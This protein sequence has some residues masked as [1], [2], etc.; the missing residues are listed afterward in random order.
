MPHAEMAGEPPAELTREQTVWAFGAASLFLTAM[1]FLGFAL[2]QGMALSFAIGWVIL[3]VFGYV[4]AL[5]FACGDLAHPLFKSQVMLHLMALV[6][7]LAI[8]FRN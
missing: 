7:M 1:G 3:Q 5:R 6:L 4:G 2:A 8:V